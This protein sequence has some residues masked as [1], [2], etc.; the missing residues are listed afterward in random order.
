MSLSGKGRDA[1]L[2]TLS[3]GRE[4]AAYTY[5]TAEPSPPS[6]HSPHCTL[7]KYVCAM[8]L[9]P[10]VPVSDVIFGKLLSNHGKCFG[11]SNFSVW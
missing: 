5:G 9:A 1:C 7:Y 2:F 6:A 11:S 8:D 4:P 10:R 3:S